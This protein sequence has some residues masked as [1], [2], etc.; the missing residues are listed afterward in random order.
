M[1]E[2]EL[3]DLINFSKTVRVLYVE[4]DD[5]LREN[6]YGIFKIFFHNIHAAKNGTEGLKCF[7]NSKYDLIITAIDMPN[8]SGVEM[9]SKIRVIS[10]DVTVLITSSDTENFIDLIRLGIDGYIIKPVEIEQFT[11]IIQKVIEKIKNKQELHEYKNYLEDKILE[12]TQALTSLNHI[13][14]QKVIDRTQELKNQIN[15]V[16]VV[17]K[18]KSEFLANM[19]HEIRTP[20]N[21]VLGFIDLLKDDPRGKSSS[22]YVDII[23]NSSKSLLK[24]IEDILDF[25]KIES[26][27][28]DIDKVDFN[29]KAELD[30][31]IHLFDAKCLQKNISL[32]L[33]IDQELPQV[34]NTDPLRIKQIISN[35][36]SNA[37]KFTPEGKKIIIDIKYKDTSLFVSIKDEGIGIVKEKQDHIFK[38][39]GQENNSTARQHG[40]TGLGLSISS[41][42]VNLLGGILKIKSEVG[43]GSEFY[44]SIPVFVGEEIM[45]KPIN[46]KDAD[47]GNKRIL[48]VEDN[49]ANQ[50]YMKVIL[51]KI[52]LEF[53]IAND[54][55]EAIEQFRLNTYDAVL[56]D[57]NM[58]NMN[59]IEATK[60]ILEIEKQNN[61]IHTPIIALTANALKGDRER[62][63]DVGMDEYL[64]KPVDKK[65]L[66]EVLGK[67]IGD[68]I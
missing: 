5:N 45:N 52:N 4:S 39:F 57:E 61:L 20:L 59:G 9:I 47:F 10:K 2:I 50:M 40:G 27:K 8:M 54:G 53:D 12:K 63:L 34:I 41:E 66:S 49:K 17:D 14:E 36:L 64:T 16:Q 38:A 13:L 48:L 7:E 21:A 55:L 62:F 26:G 22:T 37:I 18:L 1:K 6:S 32:V 60:K 65:K 11:M 33:N 29:T 44:F 43:I 3:E 31:I 58:P 24:I 23:D 30:M 28:L 51:K 19:S 42:L 15:K 68:S 56:M 25:S 35:L 46:D 67:F